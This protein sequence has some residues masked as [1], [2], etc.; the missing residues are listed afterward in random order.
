MPMWGVSAKILKRM[1]DARSPAAKQK[2]LD[3][4]I[5]C[6]CHS[7]S[8]AYPGREHEKKAD[9]DFR[10]SALLIVLLQA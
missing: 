1:E 6:I 5:D 3:A 8:L 9:Q 10:I 2:F 7:Y 4:A